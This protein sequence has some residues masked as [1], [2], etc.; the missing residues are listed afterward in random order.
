M[1]RMTFRL[2]E[3]TSIMKYR[4]VRNVTSLN[5]LINACMHHTGSIL[6]KLTEQDV[7]SSFDENSIKL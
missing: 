3:Q 4:P 5:S 7:S 6:F 2:I 1:E